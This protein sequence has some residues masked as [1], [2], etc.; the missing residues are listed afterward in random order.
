MRTG[1]YVFFDNKYMFFST[2][3]ASLCDLS[4]VTFFDLKVK[5]KVKE[6]RPAVNDCELTE[7]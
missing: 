7:I 4:C 6:S 5:K 3:F 2:F 1:A